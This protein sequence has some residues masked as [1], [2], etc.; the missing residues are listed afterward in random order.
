MKFGQ[1]CS[2]FHLKKNKTIKFEPTWDWLEPSL[3]SLQRTHVK[4]KILFLP[5]SLLFSMALS[6]SMYNLASKHTIFLNFWSSC[7]WLYSAFSA[8]YNLMLLLHFTAR[9]IN[10]LWNWKKIQN[11]IGT[12]LK[13]F[14]HTKNSLRSYIFNC[15]N[16]V[17]G[18]VNKIPW[19]IIIFD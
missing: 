15:N 1:K 13:T 12:L 9:W 16:N 8:Y 2:N 19:Q 5:L 10:F 11:R 14:L 3:Q 4:K 7:V 18:M 17:T 6:I